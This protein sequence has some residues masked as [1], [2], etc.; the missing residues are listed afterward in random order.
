MSLLFRPS[1][2]LLLRPQYGVTT[3]RRQYSG[4]IEVDDRHTADSKE[5][6]HTPNGTAWIMAFCGVFALGGMIG[7]SSLKSNLRK[8]INPHAH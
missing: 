1:T 4:D 8:G 3:V 2:R 7:V 6:S 5:Q